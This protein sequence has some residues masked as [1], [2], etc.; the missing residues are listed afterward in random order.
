MTSRRHVLFHVQHLLGIGHVQ[1][2]AAIA[3][4]MAERDDLEVTVLSGGE[5]VPGI[6]F[7]EARVVELPSARAADASFKTLLDARGAPLD[8]A[9]HARRRDLA[10]DA[11]RRAAPDLLLIESFPFGRRAFRQELDALIDAARARGVP[12]LCSLRDIV[13]AKPDP[14]RRRAIVERVRADFARVLVHGDPAL[15]PLDA[16]FPEAGEITDRLVYTGYVVAPPV[17]VERENPASRRFPPPRPSPARGEGEDEAA[18]RPTPSPLA[19]EGRGGGDFAPAAEDGRPGAGEV[20]VS[21]GGG[22][23]GEALLRTALVAR[24]LTRST[25]AARRWRLIAGPNL[26]QPAFDA[27]A[28]SLPKDGSIALDRFRADFRERLRHCAV[29]ISQA[30]YNTVLDILD[31]G[32]RAVLV[33]FA[34]GAETEQT[35]RAELL[36]ARGRAAVVLEATLSPATLAASVDAAL[37]EPRHQAAVSVDRNGAAR[38]AAIVAA[39]AAEP[40][41]H[42]AASLPD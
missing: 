31:A 9:F 13:V 23:V 5:K 18:L 36:A 27:L 32:A 1:R 20:L 21:A 29:S 26:P 6:A 41:G 39:I 2:A 11:F 22:A 24:E 28:A 19:G 42:G 25:A 38:T 12:V 15:L 4:A 14:A 17:G 35:L 34:A 8:E 33:P 3:T 37:A 40:R 7:G 30:G 10:L 16:S